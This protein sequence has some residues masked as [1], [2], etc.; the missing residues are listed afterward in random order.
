MSR[1]DHVITKGWPVV[2]FYIS[3]SGRGCQQYLSDRLCELR[4]R[5]ASSSLS[6]TWSMSIA[7][8]PADSAAGSS[9]AA[10]IHG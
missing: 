9:A 7:A 1:C 4:L 5:P 10:C 3:N 8:G 6:S 2:M